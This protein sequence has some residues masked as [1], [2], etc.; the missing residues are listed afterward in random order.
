[1]AEYELAYLCDAIKKGDVILL[2]GSGASMGSLNKQGEPVLSTK[3]LSEALAKESGFEYNNESLDD[4]YAASKQILGSNL[5]RFLDRQFRHCIPSNDYTIL[6]KFPWARI[7]TT[8]IDDAFENAIAKS[9]INS[10]QHVRTRKSRLVDR[11]QTYTSVDL[12]KLHGSVDRLE[13]GVIFSPTEYALEAAS[14][15]PWYSQIGYDY[16][17]FTFVIIGS[18]LN[19]PILYQQVQYAHNKIQKTSPRNYL[20]IP[21]ISDL[22]KTAFTESNIV[23]IPWTLTEFVH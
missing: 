23:H 20:M 15:S 14:P 11:D 8:N 5:Y 6:A 4:V 17:N 18:T 7:Y 13:E 22:H 9:T 12:I 16:Q 19:E 1:M 21:F 10:P 3:N 2:L